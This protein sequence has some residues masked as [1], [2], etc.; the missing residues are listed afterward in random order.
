MWI[1]V[2]ILALGVIGGC[3]STVTPQSIS[4]PQKVQNMVEM[5]KIFDANHGD[6]AS[7][8]AGDKE[9]YTKLAGSAAEATRWW[10]RM[11]HPPGAGGP[12]Q[13]PTGAGG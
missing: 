12:T 7:A 6:W 4:T 1:P 13:G 9:Q 11:G 2:C 8:S 5:R 3:S 10:N